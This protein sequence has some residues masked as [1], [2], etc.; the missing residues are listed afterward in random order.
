MQV[1]AKE[2][3]EWMAYSTVHPSGNLVQEEVP[4]ASPPDPVGIATQNPT[5]PGIDGSTFTHC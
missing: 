2:Q 3:P 5:V 4:G 1:K